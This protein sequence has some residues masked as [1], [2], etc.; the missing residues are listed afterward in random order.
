VENVTIY[1][2]TSILLSHRERVLNSK[3]G[4]LLQSGWSYQVGTPLVAVGWSA[5]FGFCFILRQVASK[6]S[7]LEA[8]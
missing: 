4:D 5:L 6:S 8:P 1:S 3:I 2:R 7:W